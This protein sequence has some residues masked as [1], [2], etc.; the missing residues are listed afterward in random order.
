M[1]ITCAVRKEEMMATSSIKAPI[2]VSETGAKALCE[3][4]EKGI[5][6]ERRVNNQTRRSKSSM[7]ESRKDEIDRIFT[8][9]RV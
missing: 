8:L 3:A 5:A 7:T 2:R 6:E 1:R 4:Y 9:L